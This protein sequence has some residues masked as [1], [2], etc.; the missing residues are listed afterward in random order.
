MTVFCFLVDIFF[1]LYLIHRRYK[2]NRLSGDVL[3]LAQ[4]LI[5]EQVITQGMRKNDK[6]EWWL[7]IT[8]FC[9]ISSIQTHHLMD[10]STS[11]W[12]KISDFLEQTTS[13]AQK[14]SLILCVERLKNKASYT[15]IPCY[16]ALEPFTLSDLQKVYEIVLGYKLEKKS[17]RRRFLD[18]GLLEDTGQIRKANHRPAQLYKL[19]DKSHMP[20]YFT[21]VIEGSRSPTNGS[22]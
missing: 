17:F 8:Y 3:N 4:Y 5:H 11:Y 13:V 16:F 14:N 9:L 7:S 22:F 10:H 1:R 20:Y 2:H 12:V 18:S 6:K 19:K 21:R 15:S